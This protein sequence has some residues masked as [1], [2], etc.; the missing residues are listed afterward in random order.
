MTRTPVFYAG[1]GSRETPPLILDWMREIATRLEQHGL[2]LNSGG[3]DG[4]DNAFEDGVQDRAHMQVF[5]PWNGYNRRFYGLGYY[6][7]EPMYQ[8]QA[9]VIA[10][11]HH[12]AWA[13]CTAGARQLHAR[14]VPIVMGPTLQEHVS[15]VLCWTK[16][17]KA[18]G[19]TGQ[20]LRIAEGLHI[21][22]CNLFHYATL[23]EALIDIIGYVAALGC[24]A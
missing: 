18:S 14:N 7:L 21:P 23:E 9:M 22:V 19:G 20:A 24:K 3:A 6:A 15:M 16:D 17:G 10:E 1:I 8:E 2:I 11:Q 12:P 4:A 5:L 13:R